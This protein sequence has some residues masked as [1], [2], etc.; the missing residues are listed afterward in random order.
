MLLSCLASLALHSTPVSDSQ[1]AGANPASEVR[2]V[3]VLSVEALIPEQL[4]R[5]R[6]LWKGGFAR[7][8]NE[9][10]SFPEAALPYATTQSAAGHGSFGSGSLPSAHGITRDALLDPESGMFVPSVL[11]AEVQTVSSSDLHVPGT[12]SA[13][14]VRLQQTGWAAELRA[15]WPQSRSVSISGSGAAAALVGGKTPELATWWD[16]YGRGFV[17]SSAYVEEL[18]AWLADWNRNWPVLASG[19]SWKAP[20]LE[21]LLETGTA[22]DDRGGEGSVAGRAAV[23][24]YPAPIPP[25][26]Q[27]PSSQASLAGYAYVTPLMDELVCNV[28]RAAIR[29]A[30]LG[31]DESVDL[32][33]IGLS[34][35]SIL[36]EATGPYS[37]EVT[38]CLLRADQ[39]LGELFEAFDREVGAGR[40]M[41]VLSSDRG[42]LELPEGGR[43]DAQGAVRLR[44]RARREA[45]QSMR[46]SLIKEFGQDFGA[47]MTTSADGVSFRPGAIDALGEDVDPARV[48]AVIAQALG[49]L[50]WVAGAYTREQLLAAPSQSQDPWVALFRNSY[51]PSSG[52]EVL[53]RLSHRHLLGLQS[54]TSSGSPYL[55]DRRQPLI[56]LGPGFPRGALRGSASSVDALASVLGRLGVEISGRPDSRDLFA[57]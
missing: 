19:W 47:N 3:V 36:A 49:S 8:L 38:D 17:S 53:L 9:G 23:F 54:G 50:P 10:A 37:L 45:L 14:G 1:A 40:W 6:P 42:I 21:P 48:R 11:D 56:F 55:Y 4:E 51:H 33:A 35:G 22:Q 5:L 2:L 57:Q 26:V 34:S 24:P 52:L 32:L 7:L 43:G 27:S 44:V 20:E 29:G 41:L 39:Q 12:G 16:S 15:H 31:Q 18:P 13:S 30:G 25:K 46:Q 28:A